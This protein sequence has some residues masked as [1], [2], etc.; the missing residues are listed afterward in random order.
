[1]KTCKN[2]DFDYDDSDS[3]DEIITNE[4]L[5]ES[6][7]LLK[8]ENELDVVTM[9]SSKVIDLTSIQLSREDEI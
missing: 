8:E 3:D 9:S 2:S 5:M 4:T 7:E 1:M 6:I